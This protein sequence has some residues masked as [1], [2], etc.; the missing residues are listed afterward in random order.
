MLWHKVRHKIAHSWLRVCDRIQ[1]RIVRDNLRKPGRL[2]YGPAFINPF[3]DERGVINCLVHSVALRHV[4]FVGFHFDTFV[5]RRE[6]GAKRRASQTGSP[7]KRNPGL[8]VFRTIEE[9]DYATTFP[10]LSIASAQYAEERKSCLL[11]RPACSEN[12]TLADA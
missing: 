10:I 5:K 7:S 2:S 11:F 6:V 3:E 4:G 9:T 8:L 12:R 1:L